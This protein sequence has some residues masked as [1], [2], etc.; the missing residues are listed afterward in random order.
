MNIAELDDP[1][2]GLFDFFGHDD[3]PG[4]LTV[5]MAKGVATNTDS[6]EIVAHG[7]SRV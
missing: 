4:I 3:G 5:A 1:F 6:A 2:K 7:P